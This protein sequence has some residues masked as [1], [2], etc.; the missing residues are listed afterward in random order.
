MKKRIKKKLEGQKP[1]IP[2]AVNGQL[3][4]EVAAQSSHLAIRTSEAPKS[5]FKDYNEYEKFRNLL[6]E[7]LLTRLFIHQVATAEIDPET[8]REI[9]DELTADELYHAIK[10]GISRWSK[11]PSSERE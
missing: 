1:K 3:L 11:R 5:Q 8:D 7:S 9:K 4:V 2:E 6:D 10:E